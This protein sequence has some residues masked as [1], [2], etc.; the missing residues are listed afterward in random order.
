MSQPIFVTHYMVRRP[1]AGRPEAPHPF[2]TRIGKSTRASIDQRAQVQALSRTRH[3]PAA[4]RA[5]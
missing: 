2:E 1:K 4:R 3:A 5:G